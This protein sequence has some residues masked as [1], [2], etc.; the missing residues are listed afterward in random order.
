[1]I[2]GRPQLEPD[3]PRKGR[4]TAELARSCVRALAASKLNRAA[5]LALVLGVGIGGY[6]AATDGS[7]ELQQGGWTAALTSL[8]I[9]AAYAVGFLIRRALRLALLLLGAAAGA[10]AILK[11]S[12]VDVSF[13][14]AAGYLSSKAG[15]LEGWVKSWLPSGAGAATGLFFGLRRG[16]RDE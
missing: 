13:S 11:V 10:L 5:L 15:E 12:G 7:P 1:M 3:A 16:K 8:S 2:E 9:L 4:R 6:S 14:D